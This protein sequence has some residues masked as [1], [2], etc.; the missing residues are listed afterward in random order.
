VAQAGTCSHRDAVELR[1][2][3]QL[4]SLGTKGAI[5]ANESDVGGQPTVT[6]VTRPAGFDTDNDGMSDAWETAHGLNPNSA[7]DATGDYNGDGYTNIEKYLN[8]LADNACAG[9]TPPNADAGTVPLNDATVPVADAYVPPAK[10]AAPTPGRDAGSPPS[11][12]A[13]VRTDAFIPGSDTATVRPDAGSP[14]NDGPAVLADAAAPGSDATTARPDAAASTP[15]AAL[16]TS[17]VAPGKM[18]SNVLATADAAPANPTHSDA[19]ANNPKPATGAA[20]S[21]CS[22]AMGSAHLNGHLG[23]FSLL[24]GTLLWRRRRSIR[25]RKGA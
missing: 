3:A 13:P 16:L 15:D 19:A 24:A 10:D 12:S 2:I 4:T 23:V 8:E 7:A 22:C 17:D 18:D 6:S 5:I 14:V 9:S 11:D 21:G 1:L 25:R 20:A